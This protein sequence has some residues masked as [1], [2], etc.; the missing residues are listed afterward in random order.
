VIKVGLTGGIG[1]GKSEVARL[2]ASY[3]AVVIDADALSREVVAPG[4]P[5]G[6]PCRRALRRRGAAT[7]Q[8]ARLAK[9]WAAADFVIDNSGSLDALTEQALALWT[10][11]HPLHRPE[12]PARRSP[13]EPGPNRGTT[14][15]VHDRHAGIWSR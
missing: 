6:W 15:R 14:V 1:S 8:V 10:R 13:P 3:G 12:P 9:G 11:L 4:T 7:G 2:L 5:G